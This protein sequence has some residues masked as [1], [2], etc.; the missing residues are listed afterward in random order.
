MARRKR[1]SSLKPLL[2]L[3]LVA[4]GGLAAW[5][6]GP[7]LWSRLRG[8]GTASSAHTLDVCAFAAPEAVARALEVEAVDARQLGAGPEVPAAGTC[9][10]NFKRAG[11]EGSA[12]ALVF[13][14]ASLARGGSKDLGHAY[15]Q[16]ITTGL[17]YAYKEV[18]LVLHGLGDEAA[19]AGFAATGGEPAQLVLRRGDS[20]L[21]L[22]LTGVDRAGAERLARALVERLP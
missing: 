18:P 5:Q 1:K 17:E 20:V 19:A 11:K 12:V 3:L 13:T 16:S 22:A 7:A 2:L 4:A 21:N 15:F 14:R 8:A 6:F 10:W 9:T